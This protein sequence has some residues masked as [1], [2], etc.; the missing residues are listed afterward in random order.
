MSNEPTLLF[1]FVKLTVLKTE[2]AF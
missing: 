1:F 2:S